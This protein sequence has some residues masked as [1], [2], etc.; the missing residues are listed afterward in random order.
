MQISGLQE[1]KKELKQLGAPELAEL[2]LRLSK[3]KK[4]NKEL[5]H[6]LLFHQHNPQAYTEAI[7]VH[8]QADF[9]SLNASS[10]YAVKSLRKIL[11][12]ISRQAKYMAQPEMEVEL[13]VWFCRNYLHN[14]DLKS[15]NKALQNIL[16]KQLEKIGRLMLKLHEDLQFDYQQ[17][18]DQL[19]NLALKQCSWYKNALN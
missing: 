9:D 8:L 3:Y 4:E 18:I 7:K 14:I 2:C 6:Y 11:R 13:L 17:E 1:Q 19:H 5:L 12:N 16:I 10:Y 15:N